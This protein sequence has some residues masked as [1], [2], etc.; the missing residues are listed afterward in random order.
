MDINTERIVLVMS[1]GEV[2]NEINDPYI[3]IN[4]MNLFKHLPTRQLRFVKQEV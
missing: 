2:I 1:D 3:R 4:I